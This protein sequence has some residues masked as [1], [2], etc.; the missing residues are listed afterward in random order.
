MPPFVSALVACLVVVWAT[1]ASA[2]PSKPREVFLKLQDQ[3]IRAAGIETQPL[4]QEAGGAELIV[5]G[6][7]AVPPQQLRM[8]ATP[9]AGLIESFMVAPDEDVRQ[10]EPIAQLNSS[11]LVEAQRAFLEAAAQAALAQEKLRRDEQLYK[12]RII[13]E[14]RLLVTRA[15][16]V[17]ARSALDE[18]SQ[19]LALHGMSDDEIAT[20][21][22]N[23]RIASALVIRAPISGT[24]LARHGT[25]GERVAAAAPLVTI[26]RL[27][28]IWV[29]L[30]VPIA[31]AVLLTKAERV[32]LPSYGVTGRVVRIGR[33]VDAATQ[34]VTA[35]AEF[36]IKGA[37]LRPG[38]VVQATIQVE[39][40]GA[41]Q[42][43]VPAASVVRHDGQDWIFLR[44]PDGF[45][46]VTVDVVAETSTTT[47]I[48]ADV[49]P[50]EMVASRGLLILLAELAGAAK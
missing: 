7:V 25:P 14:R 19:L 27:D 4:T 26:A 10:G 29:N 24:I 13:A 23:R 32:V 18:R 48:R 44:T 22:A 6:S 2:T 21:R 38:Q 40:S 5:P 16:N 35:V 12:E 45:R 41:P 1:C 43:R 3:Q 37:A 31:R 34:S 42:W 20:L 30:Q 47:S 33:T 36:D 46:A 9:A 49:K 50:G 39:T 28:P 17:L 15:E 8:V 11:D